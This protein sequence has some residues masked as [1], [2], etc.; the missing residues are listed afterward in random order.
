MRTSNERGIA[1]IT[2]MLVLMLI[3][4]LLVGFTTLVMSDQ[5]F[6]FIDHDRGQAF[7]AADGGTEKITA[8]LGNT[9]FRVYRAGRPAQ[10]SPRSSRR[11]TC[12]VISGSPFTG[13]APSVLPGSALRTDTCGPTQTPPTQIVTAGTAGYTI[14][15][16][17]AA[18]TLNPT[19]IQPANL[20]IKTGPYDGLVA[21]QTP[22]QIDVTA[23]TAT[24]GE[25]HLVRTI[26]SVAIPV[27]QFGTFSSVDLAFFAG[28]NFG[29]G[30][31]VHTNGNLFLAQG[32][33]ATL[34]LSGKVTAVLDVIRQ[35]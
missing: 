10:R 2:V 17:G 27:F 6:R 18:G 20:P 7:Y 5:R 24:G 22:Y 19:N 8:D 31:R 29:F 30:G 1:M 32:N 11:R 33:G 16:C 25:V 14:M 12:P 28:P 13:A 9:F 21:L 15:Y 4:A 35:W 34:T 23:T 26:E 3:S